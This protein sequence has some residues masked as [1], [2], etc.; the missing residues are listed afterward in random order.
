[1]AKINAFTITIGYYVG[2][3]FILLAFDDD[4]FGEEDTLS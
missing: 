4:V 1:M 3:P 2:T